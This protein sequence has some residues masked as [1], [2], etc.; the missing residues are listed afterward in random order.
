MVATSQHVFANTIQPVTKKF[1]NKK[2]VIILSIIS[3]TGLGLI[4]MANNNVKC[5][6]CGKGRV[7]AVSTICAACNRENSTVLSQTADDTDSVILMTE[8]L[9]HASATETAPV[10]TTSHKSWQYFIPE[11]EMH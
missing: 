10:K 3:N 6:K 4:V 7:K 2:Q 11:A 8:A 5:I 9:M 1:S